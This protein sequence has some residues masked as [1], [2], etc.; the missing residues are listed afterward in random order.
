MLQAIVIIV[1][2]TLVN[3]PSRQ[4]TTSGPGRNSIQMFSR[5]S[6]LSFGCVPLSHFLPNITYSASANESIFT[7]LFFFSTLLIEIR[8]FYVTF[9]DGDRV[10][11]HVQQWHEEIWRSRA[12]VVLRPR[13][14]LTK[15]REQYIIIIII[16]VITIFGHTR[17]HMPFAERHRQS[18]SF[19]LIT[20]RRPLISPSRY[21]PDPCGERAGYLA[22]ARVL[23]RARLAR[24]KEKNA[25][26][27]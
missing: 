15:T 1:F 12:A 4:T 27:V 11:S 19:A 20:H 2:V 23:S 17:K 9:G 10:C 24:G 5:S 21:G 22:R 8:R 18:R 25:K 3:N 7:F 16:T 13:Q 6:W 26:Y 14:S